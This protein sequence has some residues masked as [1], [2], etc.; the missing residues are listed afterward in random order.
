MSISK[1]F[2]SLVLAILAVFALVG[3]TLPTAFSRTVSEAEADL[4]YVADSIFFTEADLQVVSDLEFTTTTGWAEKITFEWS[5]SNEAVISKDGK[6]TRPEYGLGNAEVVVK[7][8]ITAEY[9]KLDDGTFKLG[10]VSTEKEWTFTVLEAGKVYTIADIKNDLTFVA[11][12]TEVSFKGVVVAFSNYKG[13]HYPFVYDG[14]DGMYVYIDSPEV[15]VGDYVQV[16]AKY[17]VYYNLVQVS[18]GGVTVLESGAELPAVEKGQ[19]SEVVAAKGYMISETVGVAA[20]KVHNV[21]AKVVVETSGGYENAYLQ[22]PFT[23]ERFIVHYETA[24]DYVPGNTAE[25]YLDLL[26]S[27]DGK[28]VNITVTN[29]DRKDGEERVCLSAY[30]IVE[31]EEPK[32]TDEQQATIILNN[33]SLESEYSADFDLPANVA[34]EVVSGTGI[35]IVEGKAIVTQTNEKQVVVLKATATY[36]EATLTKEFTVV[37]PSSKIDVVTPTDALE[38]LENAENN[39]QTVYVGG[40]ITED[41]ALDKYGNFFL[42]DGSNS[43]KI[44]GSFGKDAEGNYLFNGIK[45]QFGLAPCVYVVVKGTYSNNYKNISGL[46]IVYSSI[47]ATQATEGLTVAENDGLEVVVYGTITEDSALDKYG[48]FFLSDANGGKVKIYGAFGKDAEGNYLFNSI[49]E[50]YGLAAGVI[51]AVRGT[52]SINYKNISGLEI[53]MSMAGQT[54]EPPA[55]EHELCPECNKCL[56]KECPDGDVC[57][58]HEPVVEPEGEFKEGQAYKVSMNQT[59]AGKV[60]YFTGTMSGYYYAT[61]EDV[62]SAVDV[63]VE[64][65]AGGYHLYFLNSSNEKQYLNMVEAEGT[66]GKMHVNAVY[67]SEA[68]TLLT[69]S[70]ELKTFVTVLSDVE[71]CFGTRNDKTYTT[72][73]TSATSYAPFAIELVIVGGEIEVPTH[74]HKPCEVCGKC[75][76]PECPDGDVCQGHEEVVEGGSADFN[77][78]VPKT[79]NGDSSY[80]NTYTTTAGWVIKNSAIQCGGSKDSNPQFTVIGP[81]NTYKAVCMNG[82]VGAAGSI[83]SPTLTGGIS[84]LNIAYTKMFTDTAL[85]ATIT[86]T[87]VATGNVQTHVIDVTLD[88]NDKYTVYPVEWVLETPITGDFTIVIVNDCP[89]QNTGNKDRL[90]I[91]SIEW[92]GYEVEET[93]KEMQ[94]AELASFTKGDGKDTSYVNRTNAEGWVIENGRCDEQA[95]FGVEA[96]QIILNG[97]KSAIGKITSTVISGGVSKVSFNYGY[98]FSES[99]KVKA[100]INIKDAEGNIVATTTLEASGVEKFAVCEF[101][102]ELETVVEGDFVLEIVNGCPSNSSS[103]KDRLSIW[104]LGW[105][106]A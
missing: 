38:G 56:D 90:T 31:I 75:L 95:D 5:T 96:D 10:T 101:V 94:Y 21:D 19:I 93:P 55:H 43:V 37:V 15:K 29:Y 86:V 33:V 28:Y 11:D 45:E 4:A 99:G 80:T 46:E 14:T 60:V 16:N 84:V 12:E 73:G 57:Q 61:S 17:D 32:L 71:Y 42:E 58:G 69:Y 50:Q 88:K 9:T 51:V 87:E 79:A 34:W 98:A 102:W 22:D 72:I 8:V 44:Y 35:E 13:G 77:T 100:T 76:D 6:V 48:N 59:K 54:P 103:N 1:R 67:G 39:G 65:V 53:L 92:I 7:V 2:Y 66:D 81:D 78:I 26:K 63:Y 85:K 70:K 91:L 18:D 20:G 97:K 41:S 25:T 104:N 36:G 83:T 68:T 49:K 40:F 106:A 62:K 74:E 64:I 47:N 52:Y 82:K 89:S 23:G 105:L 30:P 3:C 27:Y 24:F